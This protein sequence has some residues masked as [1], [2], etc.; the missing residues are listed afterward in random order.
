[1]S[2]E[3]FCVGHSQNSGQ[4]PVLLFTHG[5]R[6]YRKFFPRK[7]KSWEQSPVV[8]S[9]QLSQGHTVVGELGL[10]LAPVHWAFALPT[11]WGWVQK[12]GGAGRDS[13]SLAAEPDSRVAGWTRRAGKWAEGARMEKGVKAS[14]GWGRPCKLHWGTSYISWLFILF[15][16]LLAYLYEVRTDTQNTEQWKLSFF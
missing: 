2:V 11:F 8:P 16:C 3:Q 10:T 9:S 7:V 15:I 12:M 4:F 6:S 13:G 14:T 1:M 5:C